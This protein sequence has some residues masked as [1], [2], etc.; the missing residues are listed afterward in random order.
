M[1]SLHLATAVLICLCQDIRPL[2]SNRAA[3]RTVSE[4]IRTHIMFVNVDRNMIH[5]FRSLMKLAQLSL[6]GAIF[7]SL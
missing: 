6:L 2:V 3:G 1:L 7:M 4:T 5:H